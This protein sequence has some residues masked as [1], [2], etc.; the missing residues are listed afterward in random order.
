M[1]QMLGSWNKTWYMK[2]MGSELVQRVA[3]NELAESVMAFNTNYK[4]TGLFGVYAEAK[5]HSEIFFNAPWLDGSGPTAEDIGRQLITYGRR[6]PYA[7][8][9]SRIDSVDAGTIMK[10]QIALLTGYRDISQ[11]TDSRFA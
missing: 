8:L 3:I 6:I 10:L 4:D 9:F 1:Q 7:E 2:D 5:P 11:G